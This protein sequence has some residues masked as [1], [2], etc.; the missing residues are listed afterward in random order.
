[1]STSTDTR[2][3]PETITL[4]TVLGAQDTDDAFRYYPMYRD[5]LDARYDLDALNGHGQHDQRPHPDA[6]FRMV[7]LTVRVE[8]IEP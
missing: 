8:E 5:M 1:M 6:P 2:E 7:R 3:T 4:Y